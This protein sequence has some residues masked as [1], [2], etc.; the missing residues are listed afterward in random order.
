V[1]N[2]VVPNRI[3][4]LVLDQAATTVVRA[5]ILLRDSTLA[6]EPTH[7]VNVQGVLYAI[8]NAGW[9]KYNDDGTPAADARPMPPRIVRLLPARP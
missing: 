6:A 7:V 1:Q 9:S 2:N 3:V 5:D 4:R 8:G